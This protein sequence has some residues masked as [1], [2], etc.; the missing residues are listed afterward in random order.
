M[1]ER[2]PVGAGAFL[3][4]KPVDRLCV[5]CPKEAMVELEYPNSGLLVDLCPDCKGTWLDG[6]RLEAL[7][8]RVKAPAT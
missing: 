2:D 5:R 1:I 3:F 8:E 4:G 7:R 6:G